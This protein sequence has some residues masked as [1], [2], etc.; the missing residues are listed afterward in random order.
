[1]KIRTLA[2]VL[3]GVGVLLSG[4][5]QAESFP[6]GSTMEA[7][8]KKGKLVVGTSLDGPGFSLLNPTT[9]QPEGFEVDLARLL[10]KKLTGSEENVEFVPVLS[11]NRFAFVQTG[12]IDLALATATIND[13]RKK[14]V[15]FAGPYYV[16]G[17]DVLLAKSNTTVH[18]PADL[19]NQTVCVVTGTDAGAN[20]LKL[21]PN[22]KLASLADEK[23]CAEGVTDGR[24]VALIDDGAVLV[25]FVMLSPDKLKILG[26]PFTQEPY[27]IVLKHDDAVFRSWVDTQL[28]QSISDG[29]WMKLYNKDL[30]Q[31]G[32]PQVPVIDRY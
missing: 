21:A 8:Q 6:A 28:A 18:T 19:N 31:F 17:Q 10:A 12:R 9:N 2:A 14:L 32:T 4:I 5:A 29:T 23:S 7:I 26:K 11:Q 30:K 27:G 20:L 1:M 24:Y 13:E 16:A 15:S 22:A 25:P 3:I